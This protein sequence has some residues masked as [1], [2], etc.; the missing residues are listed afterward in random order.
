M[1]DKISAT[2]SSSV[3][4]DFKIYQSIHLQHIGSVQQVVIVNDNGSSTIP[5]TK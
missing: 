1:K 4:I 5:R 3:I 2:E